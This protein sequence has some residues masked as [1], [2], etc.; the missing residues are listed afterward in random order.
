MS[1]VSR[2][3]IVA[4]LEGDKNALRALLAEIAPVVRARALRVRSHVPARF[5]ACGYEHA[6]LVQE[7]F[8][9]LFAHRGRLLLQWTPERGMSLR[10]W[11]GLIVERALR[12]LVR[13]TNVNLE[14]SGGTHRQDVAR[15]DP[16]ALLEARSDLVRL[17]ARLHDMLD[18]HRL[19]LFERL[20]IRREEISKIARETGVSEKALYAARTRME[21]L[22]R[23]LADESV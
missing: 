21:R 22:A 20:C 12:A 15:G 10:N 3:D 5:L 23:N 7:S 1:A 19:P 11:V 16:I 6:D 2:G 13:G 4:A 8:A 14:L 18:A 17:A 9:L